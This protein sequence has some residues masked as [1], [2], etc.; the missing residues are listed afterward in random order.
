MPPGFDRLGGAKRAASV[1][2]EGRVRFLSFGTAQILVFEQSDECGTKF[3]C[4]KLHARAG[5]GEKR[6]EFAL[7][8]HVR[9]IED[10][11]AVRGGFA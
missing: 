1:Y 9:A 5:G 4:V 3:F 7:A 8:F 10:G 6:G 11:D 2:L